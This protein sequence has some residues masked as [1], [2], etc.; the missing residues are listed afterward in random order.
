VAAALWWLALAPLA[1]A[2]L[3]VAR[4]RRLTGAYWLV[5][6]M[7]ITGA[8]Q[9]VFL[10]SVVGVRHLLP[11]YA[12]LMLPTAKGLCWVAARRTV[13]GHLAVAA[14][15]AGGFVGHEGIQLRLLHTAVHNGRPSR[16]A[17]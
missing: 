7:G 16:L 11:T 14:I 6:A 10:L 3:A 8:A 4:R 17:V 1:T 13:A 9:Y 5:T 15:L 12:L 2:G